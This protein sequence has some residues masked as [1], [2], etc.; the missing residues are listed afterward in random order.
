M[1][2][3]PGRARERAW[4]RKFED[5]GL[6]GKIG[7][8]ELAALA[9][10]LYRTIEAGKAAGRAGPAAGLA[11]RYASAALAKHP[12]ARRIA[13][14]KGCGFCCH[15]RVTAAAPEIFRLAEVIGAAPSGSEDAARIESWLTGAAAAPKDPAR[16]RLPCAFLDTDQSCRRHADRPLACR[17]A[18]SFEVRSCIAWFE[19]PGAAQTAALS[20]LNI[21]S[22]ARLALWAGLRAA[23]LDERGFDLVEGVRAALTQT[24]A[25]ARWLAG[26][27]VFAGVTVDTSRPPE[28][29]AA[30]ARLAAGAAGASGPAPGLV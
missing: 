8:P 13:C 26:E 17:G 23:G 25:E 20:S 27:A 18:A 2:S 4:K 16:F 19:T 30:I 28:V 6:S 5:G 11:E 15:Q 14:R 10:I 22:A 12:D 1:Q 24:D 3:G 9:G 21:A 29:V 7:W